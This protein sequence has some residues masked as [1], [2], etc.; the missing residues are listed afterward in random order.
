MADF[1]RSF[2]VRT[3]CTTGNFLTANWFSP[4]VLSQY[5]RYC[6]PFLRIFQYCTLTPRGCTWLL[7]YYLLSF[8]TLWL[9][10]IFF[11]SAKALRHPQQHELCALAVVPYTPVVLVSSI[12]MLLLP[13]LF[14]SV[15]F[16]V[17]YFVSV[18][19]FYFISTCHNLFAT[20]SG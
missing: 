14:L 17:V 13:F 18:V 20:C 6:F 10:T 8:L 11:F 2:R 19:L 12:N 1:R 16:Y 15:L 4:R 7:G 3:N 9:L 5:P